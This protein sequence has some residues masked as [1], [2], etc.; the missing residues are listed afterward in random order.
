MINLIPSEMKVQLEFAKKNTGVLGYMLKCGGALGAVLIIFLL[1]GVV[2]AIRLESAKSQ[3][4]I[5]QAEIDSL[6]VVEPKAKE[7]A[8]RLSLISKA[9]ADQAKFSLLL[10]DIAKVMPKGASLSSITLTGEAAKPVR[11]QISADSYESAV[12][13]RDGIVTSPR[14]SGADIETISGS[15]SPFNATIVVAFKPGA[16][17]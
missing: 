11:I 5:K 1:T 17:K 10:A 6:A 14:I 8:G 4:Q 7:I 12:A 16:A 2:I 15:A 9:E 3:L 13:F